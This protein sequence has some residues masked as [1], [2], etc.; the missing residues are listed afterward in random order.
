MTYLYIDESGDLGFGKNGSEYFIITCVKIDD[1]KTNSVFRRIAKKVRQRKL[2]KKFKE[3]P[4]LKFSNSSDIIRNEFLTRAARLDIEI[5]SLIIKKEYTKK[6]LQENLPILYNYLINILLERPLLKIKNDYELTICLDKCMSPSQRNDFERYTKTKFLTK[7]NEIPKI[8]I[9]HDNSE[10]NG[11]LQV[12]DFICGA[13][14]YKYNTEKLKG[15]SEKYVGLIK[16][17][18]IVERADLFKNK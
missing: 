3:T 6:N 5:Y 16:P 13:F 8:L 1:E 4:E 17:K 14:S 15:T 18:I 9:T 12:I 11:G 10:L 7:F 2:S